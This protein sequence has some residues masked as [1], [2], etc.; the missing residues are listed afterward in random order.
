MSE[1]QTQRQNIFFYLLAGKCLTGIEALQLFACMRL[2]A[3]IYELKKLGIPIEDRF[4]TV[5]GKNGKQKRVKEY[6]IEPVH[7]V[8]IYKLYEEGRIQL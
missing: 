2:G 7:F 5:L 6:W 8:A 1:T 4:I 3:R